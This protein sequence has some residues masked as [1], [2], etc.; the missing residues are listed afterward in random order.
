MEATKTPISFTGWNTPRISIG[1]T[2]LRLGTPKAPFNSAD[3][4]QDLLHAILV[5]SFHFWGGSSYGFANKSVSPHH[6][7]RTDQ[8]NETAFALITRDQQGR[9][10]FDIA[11][12]RDGAIDLYVPQKSIRFVNDF[13]KLSPYKSAGR[14]NAMLIQFTAEY[15]S[16]NG[17]GHEII[18]PEKQE[19]DAVK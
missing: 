9:I 2:V 19:S 6:F 1:K 4:Y 17:P 7:I 3:V 8:P 10:N 18:V 14:T 13:R 11:P 15:S 5:Q 16:K 12:A